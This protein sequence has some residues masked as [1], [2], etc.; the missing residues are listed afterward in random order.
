MKSQGRGSDE[1]L[2]RTASRCNNG[3]CVAVATLSADVIGM[4]DTKDAKGRILE[5]RREQWE[6]FLQEVKAGL[7]DT[8][9]LPHNSQKHHPDQMD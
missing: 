7:F 1:P 2:W 8:H 3:N 4:R 5:I 6:Q 9:L